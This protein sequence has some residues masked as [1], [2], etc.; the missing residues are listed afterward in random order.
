MLLVKTSAA[1]LPCQSH[2]QAPERNKDL[3]DF[4]TY[5]VTK[6]FLL[7]W[8]ENF[9][10]ST[11]AH[12]VSIYLQFLLHE[13]TWNISIPFP[14]HLNTGSLQSCPQHK[15]RCSESCVS[16]PRTQRND[17]SFKIQM[18]KIKNSD[19]Q[20]EVQLSPLTIRPVQ[21]NVQ[22]EKKDDISW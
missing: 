17:C 10:I 21:N 16:Y 8:S 11:E 20:S 4:H 9:A 15:G 18:D 22:I 6:Q 13:I 2:F 1:L 3:L 7:A 19:G 14:V 5:C 12:W